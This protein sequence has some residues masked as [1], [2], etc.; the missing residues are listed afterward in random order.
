MLHTRQAGDH[1]FRKLLFTW[2]SLVMSLVISFCAV[3][4]STRCLG[5]KLSQ[6]LGFCYLLLRAKCNK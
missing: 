5:S 6:F 3:L 1:L 2:L 4:F